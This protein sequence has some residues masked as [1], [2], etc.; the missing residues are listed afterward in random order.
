VYCPW[1]VLATG[2]GNPPAVLVGTGKT[3]LFRSRSV[4]TPYP[5]LLAGPTS[6]LHW[7]THW[8]HFVGPNLSGTISGFAFCVVRLRVALRYSTTNRKI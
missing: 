4:Q 7:S 1:V 2:P 3:V 5:L 6:D 8:I